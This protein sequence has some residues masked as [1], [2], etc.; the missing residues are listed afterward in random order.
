MTSTYLAALL[1]LSTAS[2]LVISPSAAVRVG[3]APRR[4]AFIRADEADA[5]RSYREGEGEAATAT[6][7][8]ADAGAAADGEEAAPEAWAGP[9][10]GDF[11]L[12]YRQEKAKEQYEKD[13]PTNV[14]EKAMSRLD[15][16]LKTLAVLTVGYYTIPI[17]QGIG[18]GV[19]EGDVAG[20]VLAALNKS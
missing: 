3:L 8:T 18:Q 6:A 19:R 4:V 20:K 9:G 16:P 7:P 15:G 13:N 12:Y 10:A 1:L 11:L 17:V 2:A 14:M 5:A